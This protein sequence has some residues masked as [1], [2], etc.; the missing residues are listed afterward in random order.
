MLS[1]CDAK[2]L[3]DTWNT[4]GKFSPAILYMFGTINNK[5]CDAVNVDAK[6]P[7]TKAPCTEPAA[8]PSDCNSVTCTVSPN[9]FLRP[10]AAQ[11]SI[12][13]GIG[14]DGVIG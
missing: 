2:A 6:A 8:P 11:T 5:P 3:A 14:D 1:A 13:S 7:A 10:S 12:A 4:P 9:K